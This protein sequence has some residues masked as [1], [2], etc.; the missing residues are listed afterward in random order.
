M[1]EEKKL[2]I[3]KNLVGCII[4]KNFTQLKNFLISKHFVLKFLENLEKMT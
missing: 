4:V 3:K 1:D 2:K